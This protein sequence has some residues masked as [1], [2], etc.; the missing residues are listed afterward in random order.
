MNDAVN[1]FHCVNKEFLNFIASFGQEGVSEE[2]CAKKFS[3][4]KE[5]NYE[6]L[7]KLQIRGDILQKSDK[8]FIVVNRIG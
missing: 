7:S 4:S 1:I 6:I 8:K 2:E 5:K 3:L